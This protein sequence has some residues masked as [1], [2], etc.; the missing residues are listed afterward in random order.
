MRLTNGDWGPYLEPDP[1]YGIVS[2]IVEAA[3]AESDLSVLWGFFPWS[4]SYVLARDGQW[5]GSAAWS[6]SR[7][8]FREFYF[9]DALLPFDYVFFYRQ[10][11]A[12]NWQ[13]ANDLKGLRIGLTQNYVYGDVIQKVKESGL[14]KLE[15]ATSDEINFRKLLAGRIDLFPMDPIVGRDLLA[16][17]FSPEQTESLAIHPRVV[18]SANLHLLLSRRVAGNGRRMEQFNAGLAA[19]RQRGDIKAIVDTLPSGPA[20]LSVNYD[21]Q[22]LAIRCEF[23][24]ETVTVGS[25]LNSEGRVSKSGSTHDI[26]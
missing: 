21:R 20:H 24:I 17:Q 26:Q 4:R 25:A 2:Q 3:F 15:V 23:D 10:G 14:A 12:F 22:R 5:D 11:R 6:C 7:E 13:T 9:S 19:L 16:R 8:R 18:H 1:P